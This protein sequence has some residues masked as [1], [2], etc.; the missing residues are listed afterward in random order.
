MAQ[1]FEGQSALRRRDAP[2]ANRP[3]RLDRSRLSRRARMHWPPTSAQ[4]L[5]RVPAR[6]RYTAISKRGFDSV[7]GCVWTMVD[8]A[9]EILNRW[10]ACTKDVTQASWWHADGSRSH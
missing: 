6:V 9:M 4:S 7:P 10:N 5:S 3:V 1:R 2:K 8:A